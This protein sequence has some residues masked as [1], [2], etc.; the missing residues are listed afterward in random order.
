MAVHLVHTNFMTVT[1]SGDVLPGKV[2]TIDQVISNTT[3]EHRVIE[4]PNVP[5]SNGNPTLESYLNLEDDAGFHLRFMGV[6]II[7][8]S[9]AGSEA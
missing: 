4:N 2:G 8:T 1:Q 3:S 9:D 6:N 5:S 7:V